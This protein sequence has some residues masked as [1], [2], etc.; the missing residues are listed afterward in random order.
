MSNHRDTEGAIRS[1]IKNYRQTE[2]SIVNQ[3]YMENN[4]H[5]TTTG[6]M[7]EDVWCGLFEM[8]VPK[9]FVIGHSVFI[10]DSHGEISR[11]VDLAI[12]D[13]MYTPYIFR[14]GRLKFIPIEAVAAVIECKSNEINPGE[15]QPWHDSIV[16]LKTADKSIVRTASGVST[17]A[18]Q[19]QKSTRPIRILCAL[20]QTVSPAAKEMFDFVLTAQ[21][22]SACIDVWENETYTNLFSWYETLNFHGQAVALQALLKKEPEKIGK[23]AKEL[24]K[25]TMESYKVRDQAQNNISLLSFNFQFNQLLMIINNP[26]LFP[27]REYVKM[28]NQ[29]AQKADSPEEA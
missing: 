6:T 20:G 10:M 29:I 27:H 21:K 5:G 4:I 17:A 28:F 9:K 24:E 1:I 16:T 3:L 2:Q 23:P 12:I 14:Y 25:V 26:M 15:L 22:N 11:E 18:V 7:R 8:I 19:T 13:E